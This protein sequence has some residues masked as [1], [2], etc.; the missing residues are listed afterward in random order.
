[1]V[2]NAIR[3]RQSGNYPR[4]PEKSG[5]RATFIELPALSATF[6]MVPIGD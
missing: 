1:M 6:G 4:V 5:F 3:N 2:M